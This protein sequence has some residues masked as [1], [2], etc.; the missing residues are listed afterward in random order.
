MSL[1][2]LL[3]YVAR[4][5]PSRAVYLVHLSDS[6]LCPGGTGIRVPEKIAAPGPHARPGH[7]PPLPHPRCQSEWQAGAEAV[8]A[9]H[10]LSVP[11][12]VSRDGQTVEV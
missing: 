3:G 9:A 4:W 8:F 11:V 2:R 7:E 12:V 6:D 5:R 10:G 1:Q